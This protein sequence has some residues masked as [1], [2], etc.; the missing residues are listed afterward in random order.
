MKIFD[1]FGSEI[2]TVYADQATAGT[3]TTTWNG[4]NYNGT[5]VAPGAYIVR[6]VGEGFSLTNKITVAR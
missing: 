1:V 3:L 2:N 5:P 6:V 4:T